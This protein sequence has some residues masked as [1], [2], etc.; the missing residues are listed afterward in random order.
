MNPAEDNTSKPS[1][2][3]LL[4]SV[5]KQAELTDEPEK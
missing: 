2:R 3:E 1:S 5:L 4:G